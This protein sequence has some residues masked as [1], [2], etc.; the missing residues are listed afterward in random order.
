MASTTTLKVPEELKARITSA[1]RA[2]G[3]SPHAFMLEA[4][5]AQAS[6]AET[7]QSFV[8]DAITSAIDIDAGGPLYAMADVHA[9]VLARTA[10]KAASRP[11]PVVRSDTARKARATNRTGR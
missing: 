9:Y 6:L 1:A 5:E 4:L 10:G 2:S 8:N 11:N 7:R 3:R